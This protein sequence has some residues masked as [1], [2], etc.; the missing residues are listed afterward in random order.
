[1]L[2]VSVSSCYEKV[3]TRVPCEQIGDTGRLLGADG[4]AALGEAAQEGCSG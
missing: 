4:L 3:E 2:S 1:M